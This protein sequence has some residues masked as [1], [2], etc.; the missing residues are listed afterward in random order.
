MSENAT[1]NMKALLYS[2]MVGLSVAAVV[3]FM[4]N[5]GGI[6]SGQQPI[7]KEQ[8]VQKLLDQI[9]QE[10]SEKFPNDPPRSSS[11]GLY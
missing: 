10:M 8:T 11:D 4:S 9:R 2:Q 6:E 5:S 7:T 1:S 3:Y